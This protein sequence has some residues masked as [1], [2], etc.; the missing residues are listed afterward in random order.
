MVL[1]DGKNLEMNNFIMLDYFYHL[2]FPRKSIPGDGLAL[3]LH[4]GA[5]GDGLGP[6]GPG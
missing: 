2:N 6:D 4:L 1:A 3:G 5:F